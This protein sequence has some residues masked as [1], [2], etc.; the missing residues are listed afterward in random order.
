MAKLSADHPVVSADEALRR[1][2]EGNARFRR[3][4][5][6]FPESQKPTIMSA[7]KSPTDVGSTTISASGSG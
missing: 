6:R 4:E 3:G 5:A 2:V 7:E 1:L